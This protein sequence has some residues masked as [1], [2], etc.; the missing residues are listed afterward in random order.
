MKLAALLGGLLLVLMIAACATSS[1]PVA[2]SERQAK[3]TT[4]TEPPTAEPT[5]TPTR[6]DG[7][8]HTLTNAYFYTGL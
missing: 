2:Q 4:A 8:P 6:A 3:P 1:Q 7:N 5:G